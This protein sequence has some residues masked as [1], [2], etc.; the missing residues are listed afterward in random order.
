[1]KKYNATGTV[2]YTR[3]GS[4]SPFTLNGDDTI[5]TSWFTVAGCYGNSNAL[6]TST[7]T[8]DVLYAVP[9]I[10]PSVPN[11]VRLLSIATSS[12]VAS[13]HTRV[14]IYTNKDDSS[15]LYPDA[16]VID[17]GELDTSGATTVTVAVSGSLTPGNLYWFAY[18]HDL[19]TSTF[20]ILGLGTVS[21]ILGADN[22]LST[23]PT[24]MLSVSRAYAALPSTFTSGAVGDVIR[25]LECCITY[26]RLKW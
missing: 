19:G 25:P 20:R 15:N 24:S 18:T 1:M 9:F 7:Q 17:G 22:T 10:A 2:Q 26:G 6:S 4:C 8:A 14:G 5:A 3:R 21:P 12:G 11:S 16:L 13:N 23:T